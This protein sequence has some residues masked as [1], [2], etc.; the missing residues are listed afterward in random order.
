MEAVKRQRNRERKRLEDATLLALKME[1]GDMS[2]IIPAASRSWKKT[3]TDSP[4]EP[5]DIMTS[6]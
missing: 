5:P 4:L 6:Y 3:V 2:Q 1:G